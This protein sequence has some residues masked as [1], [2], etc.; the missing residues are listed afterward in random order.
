MNEYLLKKIYEIQRERE[1]AEIVKTGPY[2][3]YAFQFNQVETLFQT[4]T[5]KST[6]FFVSHV[7]YWRM[8]F[9][10]CSRNSAFLIWPLI[11]FAEA[12]SWLNTCEES[13]PLFFPTPG[14]WRGDLAVAVSQQEHWGNQMWCLYVK[15]GKPPSFTTCFPPSTRCSAPRVVMFLIQKSALSLSPSQKLWIRNVAS[16]R[17]S[18]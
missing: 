12:K 11:A 17:G 5:V 7:F 4:A 1:K 16:G 6:W 14:S 8:F 13:F 2:F 15:R 3:P 10:E 18:I 9:P